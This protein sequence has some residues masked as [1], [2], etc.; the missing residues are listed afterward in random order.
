LTRSRKKTDLRFPPT[1]LPLEIFFDC[2]VVSRWNCLD[3][4]AIPASAIDREGYIP[5]NV[6]KSFNKE[7]VKRV[8]R[9]GETGV[10]VSVTD[11]AARNSTT[12]SLLM[13][14]KWAPPSATAGFNEIS[15]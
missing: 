6:F 14:L 12:N 2:N 15:L 7:G 5:D 1:N 11:T 10:L 8:F 3:S 13:N 4:G 9:N